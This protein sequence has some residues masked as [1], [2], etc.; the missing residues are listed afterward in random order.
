MLILEKA[1]GF[2]L[3]LEKCGGVDS[4]SNSMPFAQAPFAAPLSL[5]IKVKGL[6]SNGTSITQFHFWVFTLLRNHWRLVDSFLDLQKMRWSL[7]MRR[8]RAISRVHIRFHTLFLLG[9]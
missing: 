2:Y 6:K 7:F 1:D 4:P 3:L 8:D 5:K 9:C